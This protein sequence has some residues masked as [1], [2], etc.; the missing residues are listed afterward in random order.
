[1][2]NS[3][4]QNF[5]SE[6]LI[7]FVTAI[8]PRSAYNDE[9]DEEDEEDEENITV[10]MT[11]GETATDEMTSPGREQ[12]SPMDEVTGTTPAQQ[13]PPPVPLGKRRRKV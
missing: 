8:A 11:T 13:S 4:L 6:D 5:G 1:M 9:D 12:S 3:E 7:N 10:D 2:R